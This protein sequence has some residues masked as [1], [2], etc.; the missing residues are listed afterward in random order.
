[1][2]ERDI[3]YYKQLA[4]QFGVKEK[5]FDDKEDYNELEGLKASYQK[6][7]ASARVNH[8]EQ[9]IKVNKLKEEGKADKALKLEVKVKKK[10]AEISKFK[11][12]ISSVQ[13]KIDKKKLDIR[14]IEGELEKL[15]SELRVNFADKFTEM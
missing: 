1:M 8:H 14:K 13:S 6:K 10:E 12:T 9:M 7:Q 4:K 2:T 11:Q 15:E 5:L 3:K